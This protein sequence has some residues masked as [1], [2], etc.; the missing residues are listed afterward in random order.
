MLDTIYSLPTWVLGVL[1]VGLAAAVSGLGLLV[2]H[3]FV[4]TEV[5]RAHDDIAGYVSNSAAFVYAVL[6]AFL[7]VGVWEDYGKAQLTAQREAAA[8]SDVFRAAEGYPEAFRQRVERASAPMSTWSSARNGRQA[9]DRMTDVGW[10]AIEALHRTMLDFEPRGHGSRSST[11]RRC[12]TCTR[13]STS[14]ACAS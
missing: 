10:R 6:L 7:A 1:V 8:A 4:P 3:H 13:S 11:P 2:V 12:A 9:R 5:R 14:G